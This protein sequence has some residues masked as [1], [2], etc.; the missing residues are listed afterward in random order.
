MLLIL[1]LC[2]IFSP[3]KQAVTSAF[4][5]V[6]SQPQTVTRYETKNIEDLTVGLVIPAHNPLGVEDDVLNYERPNERT[7]RKLNLISPKNNGTFSEI[8]LLRP[9]WWLEK[10][11]AQIGGEVWVEVPE[12]GISGLAKLLSIEPCPLI[13]NKEGHVITGTF[14]HVADRII[15]IWIEGEPNPIGCTPNHPFWCEDVN[16]F[17]PVGQLQVGSK[18]RLLNNSIV[19]VLQIKER[20]KHNQYVYNIEVHSQHTYYVGMNGVL[21]HNTRPCNNGNGAVHGGSEHNSAIDNHI[22]K[23]KNNPQVI[24]I[25]KNQR[26]VDVVGTKYKGNNRPD[27]QYDFKKPNGEIIHVN[28]EY[29]HNVN[30][31]IKHKNKI[32]QNDPVSVV[33]TRL[34]Q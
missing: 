14:K 2:G 7:W 11:Q 32:M 29:D 27:I 8:T 6:M 12:C 17:V 20:E 26:Q 1:G 33:V 4:R 18:L 21:V 9:L 22:T 15:D 30:N 23:L 24:N 10:Q 28:I 34:L 19:N 13:E 16:N 5:S 3:A 25:R 31:S